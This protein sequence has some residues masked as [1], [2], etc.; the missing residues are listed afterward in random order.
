[1]KTKSAKNQNQSP[2]ILNKE[3]KEHG[4]GNP[5]ASNNV[6]TGSP[7]KGSQSPITRRE[8]SGLEYETNFREPK[9]QPHWI[10]ASCTKIHPR[11]DIAKVTEFRLK[12]QHPL[13]RKNADNSG[14]VSIK[15]QLTKSTKVLND[16][17]DLKKLALFC[18]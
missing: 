7:T 16:R 2:K 1:M 4:G 11:D 18:K 10:P 13:P 14:Q 15:N 12:L 8:S 3:K 6:G 9:L 17:L 5:T